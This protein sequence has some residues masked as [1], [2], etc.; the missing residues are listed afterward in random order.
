MLVTFGL[1][2]LGI[3]AGVR[4]AAGWY[5]ILLEEP[6][7]L[8]SALVAAPLGFLIGIGC[9][10]Y[11]WNYLRGRRV[12]HEDHSMH[13]ATTGRTTCAPTPTTR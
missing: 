7:V 6:T 5:P 11:W 10:D 1:L 8:I 9:F 12:G 13:G 2:G 3:V 4:Y